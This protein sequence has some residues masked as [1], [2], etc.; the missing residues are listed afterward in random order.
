M[1]LKVAADADDKL[2]LATQCCVE[3]VTNIWY[4]KLHPEQSSIRHKV[5]LF[6]GFV[7]LGLAAPVFVSYR[8]IKKV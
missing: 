5:S 4:D 6:V 3:A 7:S 8:K 2:F 1:N